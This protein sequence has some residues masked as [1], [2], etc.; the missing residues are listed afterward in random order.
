M[1]AGIGDPQHAI[2][3]DQA[4]GTHEFTG[5]LTVTAPLGDEIAVGIKLLDAVRGVVLP[6][7]NRTLVVADR[8]GDERELS[9]QVPSRAPDLFRFGNCTLGC[10]TACGNSGYRRPGCV[11]R[12]P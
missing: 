12:H 8:I 9:R 7:V 2:A 3:N 11:C 6:D 1:V 5:L 10:R 4:L